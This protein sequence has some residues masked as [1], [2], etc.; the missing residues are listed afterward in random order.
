MNLDRLSLTKRLSLGFSFV[1]AAVIAL[2]AVATFVN[3]RLTTTFHGYKDTA[4]K[5]TVLV[6]N[7]AD[8]LEARI[9]N[10]AYRRDAT[11]ENASEVMSNLAEI[12]DADGAVF[13]EYPDLLAEIT[14]VQAAASEYGMTFLRTVEI[15]DQLEAELAGMR[16]LGSDARLTLTEVHSGVASNGLSAYAIEAAGNSIQSLLLSLLYAEQFVL[17]GDAAALETAKDHLGTLRSVGRTLTVALMGREV[18]LGQAQAAL[19]GMAAFEASLDQAAALIAER[20]RLRGEV[21]DVLSASAIDRIDLARA[22]VQAMQSQ[23][24]ASS[25]ALL[26]RTRVLVPA[27]ALVALVLSVL[28]AVLTGRSATR[29]LGALGATTRRLADGDVDVDVN[30]TQHDHELGRM[31]RALVVFKNNEIERRAAQQAAD[32]AHAAQE[33]VVA[34]LSAS[35]ERLAG[36]DLSARLEGEIP[37]EFAA[38]QTNFNRTMERLNETISEVV[39]TANWLSENAAALGDAT[40]QLSRR[41]ENQAAAIEETSAAATTL[42]GSVKETAARAAQA[43]TFAATTRER[44][45]HGARTVEDTTHAM[46]RIRT[47]S[48]SI[49]DII[50]MIE[51]V[52]FQ[53]NLLALNAGVEAARAGDAGRG[54]AVVASEVGAL[55]RRSAEAV[56]EIRRIIEKAAEDVASG[57][58]TVGQAGTSIREI[59]DMVDQIAALIG[60][61]SDASNEQS[62]SLL[63]TNASVKQIDSMTQENAAMSEE[64]AATAKRLADGAESLLKL[65]AQFR[66]TA[67]AQGDNARLVA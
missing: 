46:D 33:R 10:E 17:T 15:Q 32:A 2:A 63:A 26:N 67:A 25:E 16:D 11:E 44:S 18:L 65:T 21:M 51:D 43:K 37:P 34:L 1:I 49:S 52:A 39:E 24:G 22:N 19:D 60:E 29:A 13:E 55:S 5:N 57:V 4:E 30:G 27:G 62:E 9:A 8:L 50:S 3:W 14:A 23:S 53:T 36:G 6:S 61:I 12:T 40:T 56:S 35:L 59:G 41:N 45:G 66:T 47:S 38:L 28:I 31:A 54:F 7:L 58:E 64:T 48:E 42:A 20:D